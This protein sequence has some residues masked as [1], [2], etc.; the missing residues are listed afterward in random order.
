[1]PH[2]FALEGHKPLRD[3][4]TVEFLRRQNIFVAGVLVLGTSMLTSLAIGWLAV[5]G[6]RKLGYKSR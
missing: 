3:S 4:A 1:M 5:G 2:V 6:L